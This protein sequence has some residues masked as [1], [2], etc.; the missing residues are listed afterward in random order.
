MIWQ[1]QVKGSKFSR[2]VMGVIMLLT[3]LTFLGSTTANTDSRKPTTREA[4]TSKKHTARRSIS[5]QHAWQRFVSADFFRSMEQ[6][7][8]CYSLPQ[9]KRLLQTAY[10]T[11]CNKKIPPL[12]IQMA[13][14]LHAPRSIDPISPSSLG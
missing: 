8:I 3:L 12:E 14:Q 6:I 10:Y 13:I 7:S 4:I 1:N 5:L 11:H 9:Y 2:L